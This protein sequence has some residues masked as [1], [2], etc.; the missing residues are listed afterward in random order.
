MI[1]KDRSK[2]LQGRFKI[3]FVEVMTVVLVILIVPSFTILMILDLFTTLELQEQ[4]DVCID[5]GFDGIAEYEQYGIIHC[6]N[7]VEK[8]VL[9]YCKD[10]KEIHP[11]ELK[12]KELEK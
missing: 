9:D 7:Q 12:E 1:K 11:I 8:C 5:L 3:G 10:S 6:Y 2:C 4:R